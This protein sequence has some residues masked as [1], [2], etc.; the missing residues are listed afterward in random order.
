MAGLLLGR[1]PPLVIERAAPDHHV[2]FGDW[3]LE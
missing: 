2:A 1:C 3:D